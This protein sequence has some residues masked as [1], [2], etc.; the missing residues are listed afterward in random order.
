MLIVLDDV[1][2][3]RRQV[4]P[5]KDLLGAGSAA[6]QPQQRSKLLLTTRVREVATSAGGLAELAQCE[7]EVALRMLAKYMGRPDDADQM[8]GDADA[9]AFQRVAR[10][11]G[12]ERTRDG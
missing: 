6:A 3:Y 8:R 12:A 5:F 9:D 4:K 2:E 1:W 11:R 7:E 10:A